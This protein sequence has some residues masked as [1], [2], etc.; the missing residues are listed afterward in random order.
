MG[1]ARVDVAKVTWSGMEWSGMEWSGMEW[2]GM[3]A[4]TRCEE[5]YEVKVDDISFRKR[6]SS[7]SRVSASRSWRL[8][9]WR[10]PGCITPKDMAPDGSW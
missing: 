10:D 2:S 4:R 9:V 8:W 3:G 1:L 7:D 5:G 6:T